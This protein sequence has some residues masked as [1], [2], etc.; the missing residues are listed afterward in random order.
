MRPT[1]PRWATAVRRRSDTPS[2]WRAG[3]LPRGYAVRMDPLGVLLLPVRAPVRGIRLVGRARD[4]LNTLAERPR[5]SPD[6][7]E[8]ARR[9]VDAVI[10]ELGALIATVGD[11]LAEARAVRATA[12]EL[13]AP[14]R[15]LA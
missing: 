11:A 1:L 3:G 14:V 12:L 9:R 7:V 8:E 2:S 15:A 4:D 6:A 5:R 13:E 10:V